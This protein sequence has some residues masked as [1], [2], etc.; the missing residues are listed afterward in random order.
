MNRLRL[1]VLLVLGSGCSPAPAV[2]VAGASVACTGPGGCAGGQVCNAAGSGF[3]ACLCGAA[4]A[5]ISVDANPSP[6]GGST[7]DAGSAAPDAAITPTMGAIRVHWMF[8]RGPTMLT[9]GDIATL[10]HISVLATT[11]TGAT[12][13]M[14]PCAGGVGTTRDLAFGA[15]DFVVDATDGAGA[16]LGSSPVRPVTLA[17]SPCDAQ[18]GTTCVQDETVVLQIF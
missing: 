8:M 16:S 5:G 9:C 14:F 11:A 4:D 17:A 12:E 6:D 1:L 18:V 13:D 3:E 2:C 10:D 15:Y 7:D